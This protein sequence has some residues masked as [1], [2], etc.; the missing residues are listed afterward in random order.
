VPELSR[1]HRVPHRAAQLRGWRVDLHAHQQELAEASVD[2]GVDAGEHRADRGLD[3]QRAEQ[4]WRRAAT[5]Q[6]V[7]IVEHDRRLVQRGGIQRAPQDRRRVAGHERAAVDEHE[8]REGVEHEVVGEHRLARAGRPEQEQRGR[9]QPARGVVEPRRRAGGGDV[10]VVERVARPRAHL[11]AHHRPGRRATGRRAH[12]REVRRAVHGATEQELRRRSGQPDR[13]AQRDVAARGRHALDHALGDQRRARRERLAQVER[14][15]EIAAQEQPADRICGDLTMTRLA[16]KPGQQRLDRR[17]DRARQAQAH[18]QL[19]ERAQLEARR[20]LE[21]RDAGQ[22]LH[23]GES[24]DMVGFGLVHHGA[25]AIPSVL[26]PR[27]DRVPDRVIEQGPRP[28]QQGIEEARVGLVGD[29]RHNDA[30]RSAI[31]WS[32]CLGSGSIAS[33]RLRIRAMKNAAK[34]LTRIWNSFPTVASLLP[35]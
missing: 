20:E 19:V 4:P 5:E 30:R 28:R 11:Q 7:G 6:Q 31:A 22:R 2:L 33:A 10:I 29:R 15:L 17:V 12:H 23:L 9:Q 24:P 26:G 13:L 1:N 21:V 14:E 8:R 3:Q 16:M 25:A 18:Q 34:S 35:P 27:P 32:R